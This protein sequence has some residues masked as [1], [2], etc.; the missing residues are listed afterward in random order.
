M[1]LNKNL[2]MDVYSGSIYKCQNLEATKC[3]SVSDGEI[4]SST[5]KQ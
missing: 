1:Y 2:H 4:N 3:P 5:F